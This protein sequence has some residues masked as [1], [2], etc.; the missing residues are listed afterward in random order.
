MVEHVEEKPEVVDSHENGDAPAEAKNESN[1]SLKEDGE[2]EKMEQDLEDGE[3]KSKKSDDEKEDKKIDEPEAKP[4]VVDL[5]DEP[6]IKLPEELHKTS[7]IFL[8]NLA[9]TITKAEVEAV[10][11]LFPRKLLVNSNFLHDF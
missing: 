1:D 11:R 2:E 10:I 9:P 7:S 8:R 5:V 4:E 6:K 3:E